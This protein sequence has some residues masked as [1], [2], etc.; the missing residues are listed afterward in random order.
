[1]RKIQ[2]IYLL[3]IASFSLVG[4]NS[5]YFNLGE[6]TGIDIQSFSISLESASAELKQSLPSSFRNSFR[7]FST[8]FYLHTSSFNGDIPSGFE[9]AL[10]SVENSSLYY[11]LIG[12]QINERNSVSKFWID[13]KLPTSDS[14]DCLSANEVLLIKSKLES[15]LNSFNN[16]SNNSYA[17]AE[18]ECIS[19]LKN[20]ID[21][22]IHCCYLQNNNEDCTLSILDG[23][24]ILRDLYER[25]Y[26]GFPINITNVVSVW[27]N[28]EI[29]RTS[30]NV[31]FYSGV[32][33]N[34]GNITNCNMEEN[35]CEF[36]LSLPN[37]YS[38]KIYVTDNST[39]ND[40]VNIIISDFTNNQYDF[41]GHFHLYDATGN[42]G[43]PDLILFNDYSEIELAWCQYF[44]E[45]DPFNKWYTPFGF[46][47][48][49]PIPDDNNVPDK[50]GYW[51]KVWLGQGSHI[52]KTTEYAI[53]HNIPTSNIFF[54]DIS[55][56]IDPLVFALQLG[57]ELNL[58]ITFSR[59]AVSFSIIY[60]PS[61]YNNEISEDLSIF[62]SNNISSFEAP[63]YGWNV[64]G[65][66]HCGNTVGAEWDL[67][68]KEDG[69]PIIDK[70]WTAAYLN[71]QNMFFGGAFKGVKPKVK[72]AAV[73]S[74]NGFNVYTYKVGDLIYHGFTSR[75][76]SE[77][78]AEHARK[79]TLNGDQ[80]FDELWL[81]DKIPSKD[82]AKG[83]E[84][85]FISWHKYYKK[86]ALNIIN[87]ISPDKI[88]DQQRI[89]K[90]RINDAYE[91][92]KNT[93]GI[94]I[95]D[96][97]NL[98]DMYEASKT[99]YTNKTTLPW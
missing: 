16:V 58:P 7:V 12:R 3:L 89:F 27:Q 79:L 67:L 63:W 5:A 97:Y 96:G 33:F 82:I 4:Q 13:L 24:E 88:V 59:A 68:W 87:S 72:H 14:L 70:D 90:K 51:R 95:P 34:I 76:F 83:I 37:T 81:Y 56:E 10:D 18:L 92:L 52:V 86:D 31:E 80:L 21:D 65:Y 41:A 39:Y 84:Q 48:S 71:C 91:Y 1:M 36:L 75:E 64:N 9:H 45:Y 20:E 43:I 35:L 23:D 40:Y 57:L 11:L 47:G 54:F 78:I 28:I 77:R 25:G 26:Q 32:E 50:I 53:D 44:N 62:R 6:N 93:P 15:L 73:K 94:K 85:L 98:D 49:N 61:I 17:S 29:E 74:V 8:G 22:V 55:E 66:F 2:L 42:D 46:A 30:C 19:F 99:Y 60:E 69:E 38:H